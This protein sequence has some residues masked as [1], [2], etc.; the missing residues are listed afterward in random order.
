MA[1]VGALEKL[2]WWATMKSFD[3]Y[4]A[5]RRSRKPVA[6]LLYDEK[7]GKLGINIPE[8]IAEFELPLFLA[9]FVQQG[10]RHIPDKWARKWVAERVAPQGR[11][12]LGEILRANGLDSYDEM[13]LLEAAQGRSAQDDFLIRPTP[14][15]EYAVV[16]MEFEGHDVPQPKRA[17][18]SWCEELGPK[19][20]S[21]R[22]SLGIT[23]RELAEKTGIDQAAISR[24]ES[25]RANPTLDTLDALAQ[26][27]GAS[28]RI[29]FS[30][31][32]APDEQ[33]T[34][35]RSFFRRGKRSL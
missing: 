22:K 15:Y 25:G 9:L 12:N 18:R 16:D 17:S 1:A 6:Q 4:N 10:R 32:E 21:R 19:I 30:S 11:Q 31:R 27:V 34:G 23:Q 20:A 24:I 5:S 3:I 35:F 7:S 28:L 8:G 2:E 14:S 26:A 29:D 13:A 33:G